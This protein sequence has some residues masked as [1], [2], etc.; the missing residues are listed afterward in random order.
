MLHVA[1]VDLGASNGRVMLCCFDG[2][3]LSLREVRRFKNGPTKLADGLYWDIYALLDNVI[4]GLVEA[5][6]LGGDVV[7]IGIDTWGCDFGLLDRDGHLIRLPNHYRDSRNEAY[8][9]EVVDKL[10]RDTLFTIT[11][12]QI[13]P[14]NTLFQLY[15]IGQE[16]PWV[17]SESVS[18]LMIPDLLNYFLTGE[19]MSERSIAS[20]TQLVDM[21]KGS[22]NVQLLD[23]LGLPNRIMPRIATTGTVLGKLRANLCGAPHLERVKVISTVSH[24]TE[25]AIVAIPSDSKRVYVCSGTWSLIGVT[26]DNPLINASVAQLGWTNEI[27]VYGIQ[28]MKNMAGLWI[29]QQIQEYLRLHGQRLDINTLVALAEQE[30]EFL[31]LFN[32]DD[33]RLMGVSNVIL[34]IRN[35]CI[36]TKQRMPVTIGAMVRGVLESLALNYRLAL[37]QL[38]S[39]TSRQYDSIYIVG[40]GARNTLLNQF[41]ANATGRTVIAGSTEA[42]AVGNA[43]VQLFSMGYISSRNELV[44]VATHSQRT[45]EYTPSDTERWSLAYSKFLEVI[46]VSVVDQ[47]L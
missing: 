22:W 36:E 2:K 5:G 44:E 37:E 8:M 4:D 11:G 16:S 40:G 26:L 19:R 41:V 39:L 33:P 32:P 17:L 21:S 9:Y 24:D 20:T 6:E 15:R 10:G 7:S 43:L 30:E 42:S 23:D 34:T 38:E 47:G 18:L 45:V 28:F 3:S 12:T 14:I 46:G 25:A 29:L 1:S 31:F 27:G 13:L 35:I